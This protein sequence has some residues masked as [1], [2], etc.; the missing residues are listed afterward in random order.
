M[1]AVEHNRSTLEFVAARLRRGDPA[2]LLIVAEATGS[3]PGRPGFKMAADTAGN[4][5]GTIG[6]G[7]VEYRMVEE[8]RAALKN[9]PVP[10][11]VRRLAHHAHPGPGVEDSGMICGGEQTVLLFVARPE[12]APVIESW[13]LGRP[14]RI[15]LTPS[16]LRF[17]PAPPG[18]SC[19]HFLRE[20]E[21]WRYEEPVGVEPT[22]YLVGGGHV[23]QALA[24][25]LPELSFRVMMMDPRPDCVAPTDPRVE[26][27]RIPYVE[28]VATQ[29]E[30]P[31]RHVLI[32]TPAHAQDYEALRTAIRREFGYLGLL[33]SR[34]KSE[35]F[36]NRLRAEGIPESSI[37]RLRSPAGLPIGSR[38]PAEIAVSIA[39]ELIAL[40]RKT[41]GT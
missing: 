10:A 35:E 17:D 1:V 16:G 22:V 33:A 4:L 29:P 21:G 3:S 20:P 2:A 8:A 18:A 24:R 15:R 26:F 37:A 39:A 25:L 34:K 41:G 12:D 36:R 11:L 6:G 27:R 5:S 19:I 40:R 38:T 32:A 9:P 23:G 30:G 7:V 14:G 31:D 13:S 28:G